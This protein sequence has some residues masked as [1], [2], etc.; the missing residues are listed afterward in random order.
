M[1]KNYSLLL[2]AF[3][4][5]L[6]SGYGQMSDLIISEYSEGSSNNKY[7]EIYNGTGSPKDLSDYE[8]WK[9]TNGGNW[10]ESLITLSGTLADGDVYIIANSASNGVILAEADLT[11]G[12]A[13]WNG[14][15]AVGL[16]KLGSLIDVVGTNGADP[17][18]GWDVAGVNNATANHTLIR[19]ST[20]CDPTTN[21]TASSGTNTTD[22]EWIVYNQDEWTYI[23]AHTETCSPT[24]DLEIT[25]SPTDHGSLC[26]GSSGSTVQYTIT[27]N[28]PI[29]TALNV[30]VTSSDTQFTVSGLSTTTIAPAGTATFDVVFTPTATGAQAATITV[31]STTIADDATINL[32]GTGITT[33][34][35]TTQPANATQVIPN[36]ATFTVAATNATSYQWEVNTGTG[37]NIVTGGSGDTTA[38]YTT[39]A[40]TEAMNGNQYRCIVTNTCGS[41]TSTATTLTLSNSLPSNAQS[42]NG[43]FEDTTA[44][45]TWNNPSTPP[46][47]GYI[48]FAIEGT[49]PPT[50]PPND[51]N[52]YT[53]NSNFNAAPLETPAS[54]GKVVYKGNGTTAAITGLTEDTTYSIRIFA[55]NGETLT[56]WANGT[57]G[58]SN[59]EQIAQGDVRNLTATPLTNQVT[60]NWLNPTPTS[61]WDEILIVANQ[62]AVAFTPTGD[63]SAYTANAVYSGANQVVYKGTGNSRAITGLTNDL[64]YCFKAFIRRGTTWTQGVEV[65]ATPTLTYCDSYGDGS[66]AYLTLIKNVEFNTIN[67]ASDNT[68]NDYTDYTFISTNVNL[69]ESYNL[70]VNVNTDGAFTTTSKAWIDWNNDGDFED[71]GEDYELGNAYNVVNGATDASPLSIDVPTNAAIGSTRMRI[72]TKYGTS[73]STPCEP[74][75]DGEVEDY[76]IIIQQP[77]G[78]EITVKGNNIN[79]PSGFNAPYGLNNTLFGTINLGSSSASKTFTIKNVGLANLNLTGTPRVDITGLNPGDFSVN[80][81]PSTATLASNA[82][83]DFEIT[84]TPLADGVRTATVSIANNDATG[85]ENP[86]TF[87]IQG[88]GQCPASVTSTIWPTEGPVGT[89]ITVTSSN[90]L[91]GA[92]AQLNGVDITVLSSSTSELIL[93]LPNDVTDGN[94]VVTLTTGC[95]S[96]NSFDVIDTSISGCESGTSSTTPTDIFISEVTDATSGSSSY[97]EI[98]NGTGTAVD[99]SDYDLKL[100]NNGSTSSSGTVNLTGTLANNGVHVVTI[101]TTSCTENNLNVSPNQSEPGLG[102]INFDTNKA[103]AIVLEKTSGTNPGEKDVFGVKGSGTWANGLSFGDEGVNFRRKNDAPVLPTMTFDLA[104]WDII[105]W[106]TCGDSDYVD[107]GIYDFSLGIPPTITLQPVAPNATCDLTATLSVTATEGVAAGLSLAYQWYYLA[108]TQTTWTAVTNNATYSGATSATL[109]ID[110]TLNAIDYQFYCQVRED[111][112]TCYTASEA[113]KLKTQKAEW[114]GTQWLNGITPDMNTITII[115]GDYNTLSETSFSACQL[116]VNA[117][118]QLVIA[119][120]DYIEVINNVDVYG[121]GSNTDGILIEDKGSFVQRGDGVNAGTYTLHTN[122]VTQVN[123]RTA[124]LNNWYEYTYWSSPV[125]GETIGNGLLEAHPT[126]RY[127]Y[128]GQNYLDQTAETN[129]NNGTVIGQDD[130]DDN[131]NDWQFTSNSDVMLP[132]IGYAA[133]HNQTGFGM[134]GANY[135]YTFEG[136][137]HTG[138]YTVPIYRND[139]ELND[140]NWNFI[141]NPYAS[142]IDADAFLATNT[143]VDTNVSE[144]TTGV[145]DGAIFLWSQNSPYTD[146]NNG[147]QVLNFAQSDYAVINNTGQTAGGDGVMPTRFIPSGQ[148][149]FISLSDAASTTTFSG[150]VKTAD[151]IFNNSMRVT[152]NNNQFFR[153]ENSNPFEKLWI[154]LTSDN[155]VFNQVLIG[156]IPGATNNYDGMYYDAPKN[157]SAGTHAILYSIIENTEENNKFAIQGKSPESLH[158]EEVIP[159]GFQTSINEAT[160]YSISIGQLQGEFLTNNTIY[161]R[162]K[163]MQVVHDL[164]AS[165]YSFTSETGMFNERFEI[166]F[167]DTSLSINENQ[168]YNAL[169]IIE[170]ENGLVTFSTTED[171]QI[172]N[173]KVYDVLGRLL[174]NLNGNSS[175]ETYNLD[176]LSQAAY[177]AK[178]TLSND[179]VITK[180]AIKRN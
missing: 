12:I 54:L 11:D 168:F 91:S 129:N 87:D 114:N 33:P 130:I 156:Y 117:G 78:A 106:T 97:V 160:I 137:L 173:V 69:G 19:K 151:V 142:A 139:L 56:G 157:L 64:S 138:D 10:P 174:Y 132:G 135:E 4:F 100:Y 136:A 159:L 9:I 44:T 16:A 154:N 150:T 140:N 50:A 148:G 60:L 145:T 65:C 63:G 15:D 34:T 74:D 7:V 59:L 155:G 177:L 94:L 14:N 166:I 115:N 102:G 152:G 75:F 107:I 99:L 141:G 3:L 104:H 48:I 49:T 23:G 8:L 81:Q 127:W 170:Q 128:N 77:T 176:R 17:G 70:T 93:Q 178:V 147:N 45:L 164:S 121:D 161:L 62:G 124:P 31:S 119:D 46:T 86:F 6:V 47:G 163:L 52:T 146:T 126:R 53:A 98:F 96:F 28:A 27:N 111:G 110:N 109:S 101:G 165:N 32:T 103:D 66:D 40:T 39:S 13:T 133:M 149:F 89:E 167:K 55:Y 112:A 18:S 73:A 134:P 85:G 118:N 79:I 172:K 68:D 22:S 82:E 175:T 88:T 29:T 131:G 71:Y 72:S 143:I 169:N 1:K 5:A 105:D 113:V 120:G 84:F 123:K 43:C 30:G 83:V 158:L 36:T 20:I 37:W 35:I 90:D 57:S 58:G 76:T 42:L 21:W 92:T 38:S 24:S 122:A 153:T 179:V 41:T 108:P 95:S 51:A 171:V 125:V 67:N 61:C 80:V 144:T 116:I 25:G 2:I 26:V 180:K 162:D